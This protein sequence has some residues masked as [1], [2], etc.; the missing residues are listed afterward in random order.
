ME[1]APKLMLP[2][3]A[4]HSLPTAQITKQHEARE[5]DAYRVHKRGL[6][7]TSALL[8]A[9]LG[10]HGIL[11]HAGIFRDHSQTYIGKRRILLTGHQYDDTL[12]LR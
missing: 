5:M 10:H 4:V 1:A 2:A 9:T 12:V 11:P 7:H 8:N 3:S 6:V